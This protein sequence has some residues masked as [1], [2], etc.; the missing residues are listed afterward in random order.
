[1]CGVAI[2]LTIRLYCGR[3]YKQKGE[4][5]KNKNNAEKKLKLINT[6]KHIQAKMYIELYAHTD[7]YTIM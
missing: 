5:L 4:Y 6:Y 7:V 1:M 2:F 3:R